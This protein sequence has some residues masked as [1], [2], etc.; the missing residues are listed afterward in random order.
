MTLYEAQQQLTTSLH[1]LYDNR[2]AA[3]IADWVLEHVTGMRKIDRIMH[4]QSLLLPERLEQLQQYTRELLTHKPVQYVL[5][6]A[7][8][9]GM[10]FYVDE[11]VLI[12]R[13]ETEELVE[14]IVEEVRSKK[15]DVRNTGSGIDGL[16]PPFGDPENKDASYLLPPTSHFNILDIGT[17]S[18]CIPI[19]L[20]KKLPQATIYACDVSEQ[21]LAVAEKNATTL[22]A[23]V[24]FVQADFLDAASWPSLPAVD[25]IVSN[26]PYIPHNNQSTMLQNV[27]A[28]EPHLALFV[29]NEDP[30]LFYDAIARFAREKLLP[31]G[32]IFVEI[33]EDLGAQTKALFEAYGF[34]ADVKKDFQGKDRMV[35]A[36][37]IMG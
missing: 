37:L 2:E 27:L 21:A 33:H 32:M 24:Q 25:I 10:A 29:P 34:T 5:H 6:E 15:Y 22:H 7:W 26:P 31:G 8:F 14:W 19:S 9:S 4:K 17:G 3:N 18:G 28:W 23:P 1:E 11:S 36:S 16:T 13:P 20:K 12:P 35:K 30:L